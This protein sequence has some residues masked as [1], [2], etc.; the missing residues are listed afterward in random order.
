MEY[1]E[2]KIRISTKNQVVSY[3]DEGLITAPSVILIHGFP[4]KKEM[5][6]KQIT[7]LMENYRVVA[8]DIRGFGNSDA[9]DEIFSIELFVAD[10]ISL[11]DA[12]M[13]EKTALCGFSLGGYIALNAIVNFPNRFNSLVLCDTNCTEDNIEAKGKRM[14]AIENIMENGLEL[15]AEE[16]VKKLFA[17]VSFLKNIEEIALVKEMIIKTFNQSIYKTLHALAERT[18]TCINLPQIKVPVLILVGKQDVITP[19]DVAKSMH[20]LIRDSIIHIIDNAGHLSNLENPE[21]FN[22]QLI[23]FLKNK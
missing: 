23:K 14:M 10:L 18:E 4:L 21:I 6:N 19:P 15:Y 12:L 8:Y 20:T 22:K 3:I 11:M 13:I 17:P 16:S 2:K 7:A 5:W 1:S 9:G